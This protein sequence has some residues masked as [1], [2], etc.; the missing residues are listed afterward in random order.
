MH[1]YLVSEAWRKILLL[2][3]HIQKCLLNS[4]IAN[5]KNININKIELKIDKHRN[6]LLFDRYI[7][8]N[9]NII[10]LKEQHT[11]VIVVS[12]TKTSGD[13]IM[14]ERHGRSGNGQLMEELPYIRLSFL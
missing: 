9:Y 14:Q 11:H 4:S 8:K 3:L 13:V 2:T 6:Y 10:I 5:K 7:D 1:L 12:R